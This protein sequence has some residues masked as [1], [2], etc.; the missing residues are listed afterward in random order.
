MNRIKDNK[1]A[2]AADRAFREIKVA[3]DGNCFLRCLSFSLHGDENRH[4][5]IR[6]N[7]VAF[8]TENSK[9]FLPYIDGSIEEHLRHMSFSDGRT[10]SWATEA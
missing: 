1:L 5:D 8:M 7:I 4:D 10:E 2:K 9:D 6:K 3:D